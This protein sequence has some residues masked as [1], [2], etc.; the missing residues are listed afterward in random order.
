VLR[1]ALVAVAVLGVGLGSAVAAG[2]LRWRGAT[3]DLLDRLELS[4]VPLTTTRYDPAALEGLPPAV[5]RFFHAVLT[6]GQPIVTAVTLEQTGTFNMSETGERW[7]P[8]TSTQ[9]VTTRRP[10]FLW[11]ARVVMAPGLGVR[12]HDAYV[13][14]DGVLRAAV[15]GLVPVADLRDAPGLAEGELL[16]WF[17]EAAWYPTAL[18]PSQGVEWAAVD[19]RSA[20]ATLRD[21]AITLTLL[22]RFDDAGLVESVRADARPRTVGGAVVPSPWEGRWRRYERRDGML[23]PLEGEV[24]WILPAGPHPYWRGRITRTVYEFTR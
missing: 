14:G 11:D 20:Q 5:Q 13:A 23:V 7:R 2:H 12:V 16:R 10:G 1:I 9:R 21:G 24:A 6:P 17:A 3:R 19:D 8:F 22:F 15:L 4:R 18:L